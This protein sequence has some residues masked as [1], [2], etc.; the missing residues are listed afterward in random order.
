MEQAGDIGG[1]IM[2]CVAGNVEAINQLTA[3]IEEYLN[4]PVDREPGEEG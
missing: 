2:E 3:Q 4:V 1:L